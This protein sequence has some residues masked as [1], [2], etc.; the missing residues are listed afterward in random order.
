MPSVLLENRDY[1]RRL[2]AS[3]YRGQAY[4]HWTMTMAERAEGWL[5]ASHRRAVRELLFHALACYRLA[6]PAYC[7]MPD[8]GHFLLVG[9]NA[10]SDQLKAT[11]WFRKEWNT[12]LAPF[13]LQ[14]QAHD[15][16]LRVS[17]RERGAFANVAGY[18]LRNPVRN[19]LVEDWKDW[20]FSG[21]VFPGYPK[22]DPRKNYFCNNFWKAVL[23]QG[24]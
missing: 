17:D 15:H 2:D 14:K 5:D 3:F 21:A 13:R 20:E 11:A 1:L 6:C 22:L 18:I 19:G 4:V 10:R 8:H 9:L 24:D 23:E 12:L 7:L 16:V